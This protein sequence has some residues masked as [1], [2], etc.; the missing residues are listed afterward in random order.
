MK[1]PHNHLP[2]PS[3][4]PQMLM[5]YGDLRYAPREMARGV[6]LKFAGGEVEGLLKDSDK[7]THEH[8]TVPSVASESLSTPHVLH[9]KSL[10]LTFHLNVPYIEPY[11]H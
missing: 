8:C 1:D 3:P 10:V 5:K 2:S 6:D 11:V 9:S 7:Y 4:H